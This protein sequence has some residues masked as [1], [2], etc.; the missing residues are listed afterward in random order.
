MQLAASFSKS[1]TNN[2]KCLSLSNNFRQIF[3][4]WSLQSFGF[5]MKI[6]WFKL[7]LSVSPLGQVQAEK[8]YFL[9]VLDSKNHWKTC[10]SKK[11][12]FWVIF[13]LF[14]LFFINS[15]PFCGYFGTLLAS[16]FDDFC[17]SYFAVIFSTFFD[18]NYKNS[19]TQNIAPDL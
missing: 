3:S 8:A 5:L 4:C 7:A 17:V 14:R 9:F 6:K 2:T 13:E 12:I 19:K 16:F 11:L 1:S 10:T 18:K 15:E